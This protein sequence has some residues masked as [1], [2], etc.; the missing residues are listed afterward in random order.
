MERA[1]E[2]ARKE[3]RKHR[4]RPVD[5][6]VHAGTYRLDHTLTFGPEDSGTDRAPVRYLAAP[7][8]RVVISGGRSLRP[9]WN[10]YND[11]VKVADIG[12]GLDFDGLF[13]DG[14]RQILARY[15]N[16]DPKTAILGGYAADAISR[17]ASRPLEEPHHR[18]RTRPASGG[19]GRQLATGSPG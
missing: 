10:S 2:A 18:A 9:E 5:V 19:V 1:Q 17:A 7:G 13:L 15:P 12:A 11:T 3:V 6:V 4:P 16:Y 14:E 8:E